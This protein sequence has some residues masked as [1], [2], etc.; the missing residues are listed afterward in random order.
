MDVV[1]NGK[2]ETTSSTTLGRTL[3]RNGYVIDVEGNVW[4]TSFSPRFVTDLELWLHWRGFFSYLG[5]WRFK[6][7]FCMR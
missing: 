3:K 2:A 5:S 1:E 6:G 4:H 7:F